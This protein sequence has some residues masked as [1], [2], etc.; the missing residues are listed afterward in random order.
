MISVR[1]ILQALFY[2]QN[3]A[4]SNNESRYNIMYLLK[5]VYLTD[6]Y[7][8][9]HFGMTATGDNYFAMKLGPVASNTDNILKKN[10]RWLNSAE[11]PLC[12]S[13]REISEFDVSIDAQ[14]EDE[15]AQSVKEALDFALAN[16]GHLSNF[17][18]SE[19]SH[20]YPEWKKHA[21]ELNAE[22]KSVPMQLEDF[23]DDPDDSAHIIKHGH[24]DKFADDRIFLEALRE[25][26]DVAA[27]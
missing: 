20:N 8:I 1:K 18:L 5:M 24:G 10:T 19:L 9:R 27:V 12:D 26:W 15:L 6:R 4:P 25:D 3:H 21:H 7:H 14:A 22:V 17:D 16:F 11:V 2:I 23:F 13:V